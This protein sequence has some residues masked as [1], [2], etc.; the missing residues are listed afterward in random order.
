M[1]PNRQS[2][3]I[4]KNVLNKYIL[5]FNLYRAMGYQRMWLIIF[6][7]TLDMLSFIYK[8]NKPIKSFKELQLIK[9]NYIG[10]KKEIVP[11]Y[12]SRIDYLLYFLIGLTTL[13]PI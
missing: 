11:L 3:Q 8:R 4:F 6:G 10:V 2:E 5:F 1:P 13:D 12:M 7:K 9:L